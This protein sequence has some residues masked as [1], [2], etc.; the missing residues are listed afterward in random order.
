MK[1]SSVNF[2]RQDV[3]YR[4]YLVRL[5]FVLRYGYTL[6]SEGPEASYKMVVV[7]SLAVYITIAIP[8]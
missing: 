8:G 3:G 5:G 1:P 6:F 7:V 4:E 2:N